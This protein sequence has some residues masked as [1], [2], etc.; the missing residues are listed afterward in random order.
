MLGPEKVNVLLNQSRKDFDALLICHQ[1][2]IV[3]DFIGRRHGVFLLLFCQIKVPVVFEFAVLGHEPCDKVHIRFHRVLEQHND[4]KLLVHHGVWVFDHRTR[5]KVVL[6]KIPHLA[7]IHV[8]FGVFETD[9]QQLDH[10]L[11]DPGTHAV[12][13]VDNR[14][15]GVKEIVI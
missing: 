9:L 10:F 5:Q 13:I 4:F 3:V 1:D 2:R 12:D 7:P 11:S 14:V 8:V 15:E 6:G